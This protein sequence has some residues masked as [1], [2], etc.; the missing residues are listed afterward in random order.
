VLGT[1]LEEEEEEEAPPK[2]VGHGASPTRGVVTGVLSDVDSRPLS[3]AE[4]E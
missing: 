1:G 3:L 2:G 4:G